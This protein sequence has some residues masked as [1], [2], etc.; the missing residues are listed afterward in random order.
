MKENET[1]EMNR[2]TFLEKGHLNPKA[3]SENSFSKI[4]QAAAATHLKHFYNFFVY[5]P[6]Y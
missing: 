2:M 1:K 5:I 6:K 4:Y 3:L